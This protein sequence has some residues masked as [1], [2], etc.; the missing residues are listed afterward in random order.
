MPRRVASAAL[1]ALAVMSVA[2]GCGG[3]RDKAGGSRT[4]RLTL[5]APDGASPLTAV[6]VRE[7]EQ[8]AHGTLAIVVDGERYSSANP[9]N[10]AR[11]AGALRSGRADLALIPSRAWETQ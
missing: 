4:T 5:E 8:R 6:F 10:E 1:L 3:D 11:L 9:A 7:A 2:V